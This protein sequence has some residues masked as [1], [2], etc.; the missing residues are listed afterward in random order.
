MDLNSDRKDDARITSELEYELMTF[1][2]VVTFN[3][4]MG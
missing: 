3:H 1:Y 2:I 4:P